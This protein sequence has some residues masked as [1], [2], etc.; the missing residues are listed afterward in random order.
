MRPVEHFAVAVIPVL[1]YTVVRHRRLPSGPG[2]LLVLLASQL[3]DIIDKPLAW[4][5]GIIPSGRMLAHSVVIA[6]PLLVVGSIIAARK[7]AGR[8]A[9]LFSFVYLSHLAGDF[10]QLLWKGRDAYFFPNL[11]WPLMEA[12]PDL[13]PSF[14]ANAPPND[15]FIL[16]SLVV[17]PL[18]VLYGI[19][20]VVLSRRRT[21]DW[22]S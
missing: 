3:P 6:V 7:G 11:F 21:D 9:V 13:N 4:T 20:H 8:H 15:T 5:F 10:Y 22:H 1:V 18:V 2:L 12:N 16:V 19:V 17:F 14:A